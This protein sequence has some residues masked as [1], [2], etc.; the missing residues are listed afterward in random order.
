MT[1]A[2][3]DQL[4][5]DL[6]GNSQR[7]GV[8][9]GLERLADWFRT[10]R[11]Y[12]ELF[13]T[14][15]MQARVRLGLP[16]ILT[17]PLEELDEPLR[18]EVE[19][20]YLSACR[21]A[22]WLLWNAGEIR[23][24]WMYLRPLGEMPAVAAALAKLEPTE[25]N[26]NELIEIALHE[27]VDP[28]LGLQWVINQFGSC[29]AIT[30]YDSEVPRFRRS[31]QQAAAAVMVR[32]LH[33]ELLENIR[34]EIARQEGSQSSESE[35]K[36]TN[37]DELLHGR[38]WLFGENSYHIDTSHLASTVRIARIIEDPAS[39][40]FAWELTQYGRRLSETFQFAGDEPFA[41]VYP[42]HGLFFAAQLGAQVEAAV[43]YFRERAER[44]VPQE[45]G[46]AAAEVYV[47]LLVRLRRFPEALAA[48]AQRIPPDMRTSGFAPTLLELGQL[49]ADYDQLIRICRDRGDLLGFAAGMIAKNAP[50]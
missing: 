15:L 49:A 2:P 13:D 28:A 3:F 9:A 36:Q 33:G 45:E 41:D 10:E 42:S 14:R 31:Q 47:A 37:L 1:T 18:S 8:E 21:E 5:T 32:H 46:T 12:H 39:L 35:A 25:E 24:A 50:R 19:N 7:S 38:D 40:R 6:Q 11:R 26:R 43:Q 23:Q 16:I 29:N 20:A 22:G 48:H 34:S 17:T 27:G 44:T 4:Q 30:A